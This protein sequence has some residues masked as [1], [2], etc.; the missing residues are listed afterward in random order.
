MR[1]KKKSSKLPSEEK[2]KTLRAKKDYELRC[3]EELYYE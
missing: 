3:K 1:M 2:E